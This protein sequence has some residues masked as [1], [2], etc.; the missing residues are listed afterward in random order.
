M[1]LESLYERRDPPWQS[2]TPDSRHTVQIAF[3]KS[4]I[5]LWR[6]K[7]WFENDKAWSQ[8]MSLAKCSTADEAFKQACERL[9]VP[10]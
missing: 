1:A 2:S 7:K 4:G 9:T 5:P 10:A 3:N 6:A 8:W